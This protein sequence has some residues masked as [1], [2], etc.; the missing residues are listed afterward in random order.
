[1]SRAARLEHAILEERRL[2]MS[3]A[4]LRRWTAV[5]RPSPGR[6]VA[7]LGEGSAL[8]Y[9]GYRMDE[10]TPREEARDRK[11]DRKSRVRYNSGMRTGLLK[12]MIATIEAQKKRDAERLRKGER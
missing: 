9:R 2:D 4:S 1:M 10:R 3:S 6:I 5:P 8:T 12:T 11:R 7:A